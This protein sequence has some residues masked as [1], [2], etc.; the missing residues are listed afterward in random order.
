MKSGNYN[1]QYGPRRAAML[2]SLP[3]LSGACAAA[4]A[5]RVIRDAARARG[6][7]VD[8]ASIAPGIDV[9]LK[10]ATAHNFTGE[11]IYRSGKAYL[12]KDAAWNLALANAK[13]RDYGYKLKIWDAYRPLAAQRAMWERVPDARFVAD[14][15]KG[16]RHNRGAAVDVTL[17]TMDGRE[18]DM[19]TFFDEFTEQAAPGA[20]GISP[21]AA[22]NAALLASVMIDCGFSPLAAEWWHFDA[23]G[24]RDLDLID[25]DAALLDDS[26]D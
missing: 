22:R 9:E 23:H 6:L 17:V 2:L 10:Y 24:W 18:V 11:R 12:I 25:V 14:P 4:P 15:E 16:S 5:L 20:A 8:V 7:L 21:P 19:P 26:R 13:F 1:K 3:L